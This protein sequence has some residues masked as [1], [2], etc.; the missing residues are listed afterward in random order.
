VKDPKIQWRVVIAYC[1]ISVV[2]TLI[3]CGCCYEHLKH[4]EKQGYLDPSPGHFIMV[5]NDSLGYHVQMEVK[6]VFNSKNGITLVRL[7][8]SPDETTLVDDQIVD[9]KTYHRFQVAE[10]ALL[11]KGQQPR[12]TKKPSFFA[13][14]LDP[15]IDYPDDN[16]EK[17]K[18]HTLPTG[19]FFTTAASANALDDEAAERGASKKKTK[20]KNG[21][22]IPSV[23]A[24]KKDKQQRIQE[25]AAKRKKL[26]QQTF[27]GDHFIT[28]EEIALQAIAANAA[29]QLPTKAVGQVASVRND[30]DPQDDFELAEGDLEDG[31]FG[32]GQYEGGMLSNKERMQSALQRR[33]QKTA[34]EQAEMEKLKNDQKMA[35]MLN[36]SGKKKKKKKSKPEDD[37]A[38]DKFTSYVQKGPKPEPAMSAKASAPAAMGGANEK[39]QADAEAKDDMGIFT[40]FLGTIM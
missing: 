40:G 9:L 36:A 31:M 24:E 4:E 18:G 10:R 14:M 1:L 39:P 15:S 30:R 26:M 29:D 35:K 3:L 13:R 23:E 16:E 32:S 38:D 11:T 19:I 7:A 20:K 22:K 33:E 12:V 21:A 27:K 8:C 6:K 2:A 34:K 25:L 5:K 28:S 37:L 17:A